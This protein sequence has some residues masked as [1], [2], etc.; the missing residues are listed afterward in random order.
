MS[1]KELTIHLMENIIQ[2]FRTVKVEEKFK[3]NY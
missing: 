2:P 3:I 1:L